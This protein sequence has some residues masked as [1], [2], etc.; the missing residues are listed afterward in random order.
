M[1]AMKMPQQ[2][3]WTWLN[4]HTP[5]IR[6]RIGKVF[7]VSSRVNKVWPRIPADILL[8]QGT[9]RTNHTLC[10]V[11][12]WLY[13]SSGWGRQDVAVSLSALFICPGKK[14]IG[15]HYARAEVSCLFSWMSSRNET[16][17]WTGAVHLNNPSIMLH[18]LD[19]LMESPWHLSPC[20]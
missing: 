19:W 18:Q 16:I 15:N 13:Y 8:K 9:D 6:V 7:N 12:M 3:E 11:K 5:G 20:G 14:V 10:R 17:H 2:A 4:L 1:H